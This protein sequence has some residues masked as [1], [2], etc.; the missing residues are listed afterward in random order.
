M[1]A[2]QNRYSL[3]YDIK[4]RLLNNVVFKQG[5]ID[6]NVLEINLIDNSLPIDITDEVIEFR[7]R[8]L[9]TT[10]VYQDVSTNVTILDGANGKV[11]C[12]LMTNTL[13]CPGVVKCEI[14]RV[15]A[16]VELTTLSFNFMV[17][18][19][20]G[21]DGVLSTNYIS[22]IDNELLVISTAEG[23]RATNEITR[24][25]NEEARQTNETARVSVEVTRVTAES[26]R[27]TSETMRNTNE[28]ARV[29]SENSRVITEASRV[30]N[31]GLR[32]ISETSRGLSES[33]RQLIMSQFET[34]YNSTQ[35]TGTLPVFIDGGDFGDVVD[36]NV[37][38]GG[39]F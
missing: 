29:S 36:G 38:D 27:T 8:K 1:S 4:K 25:T 21:S 37:Y 6:S 35:L 30:A 23:L 2:T 31:E 19:S 3:N 7:F 34:W 22:A 13:A 15:K 9:D 17:E 14:H 20:I 26:G 10:T 24:G 32:T 5:D 16:G 39:D 12:I 33:E 11:E 28:G 18:V